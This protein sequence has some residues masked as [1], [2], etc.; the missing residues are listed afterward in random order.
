LFIGGIVV[1]KRVQ[2][3]LRII[4]ALQSAQK[5]SVRDLARL[6]GTSRRTIFRDLKILKRVGIPCYY[7]SVSGCHI[8]DKNFFL[9]APDLNTAETLG[10]LLSVHKARDCMYMPIKESALWAAM[11]IENNLSDK[12]KRFCSSALKHITIKGAPRVKVSF[13]DKLF[14]QLVK[15]IL[16]K[17]IVRICYNLSGEQKSELFDFRPCHLLYN[18][19]FWSVLGKLNHF[20][21]VRVF[22]LNRIKELRLLDKFF[23]E[24]EEFDIEEHLGRAWS[25]LPEGRL[26]NVSL[27]FS[28]KVAQTV[29][30]IQWHSTQTV[31]FEYDGSAIV[32]FRVDGLS[33]IKRWIL[34]YGDQV[35]VLAPQILRYE[36]VE[37]AR[38]MTK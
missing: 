21:S 37:I 10:L 22:S 9:S 29:A 27:K 20:N 8:I 12:I 23:I 34:S 33:E 11:K 32:E 24:N 15:A 19:P 38:N 30:D 16:E 25:M 13:S 26:Y 4:T 36:I 2:R 6:L 1:A 14:M 35:Q 3:V 7:D 5:Y 31:C 28:P 18:E 17:R